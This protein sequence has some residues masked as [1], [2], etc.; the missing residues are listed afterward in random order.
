MDL[1]SVIF[2]DRRAKIHAFQFAEMFFV[3]HG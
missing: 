2:V 3:T 1:R